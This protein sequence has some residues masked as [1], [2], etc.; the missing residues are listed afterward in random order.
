[1][2]PDNPDKIEDM[3]ERRQ[4]TAKQNSQADKR[5][6]ARPPQAGRVKRDSVEVHGQDTD[7]AANN[8]EAS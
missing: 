8:K 4:A 5:K 6:E 3:D 2:A 7:S 1:M